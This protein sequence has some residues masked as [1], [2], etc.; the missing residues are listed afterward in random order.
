M[1]D[2]PRCGGSGMT[3]TMKACVPCS[4]C[5]GAGFV[6]ELQSEW[7]KTG[8]S[9]QEWRMNKGFTLRGFAKEYGVLPSH[10]SKMEQGCIDPVELVAMQ[11]LIE[12][13]EI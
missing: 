4:L 8:Q 9:F 3:V 7:H 1:I 12:G 13:G 11:R 2:C 5:S 10:L 6:S